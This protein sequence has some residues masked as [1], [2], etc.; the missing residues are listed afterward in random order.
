MKAKLV[1]YT[2]ERLNKSEKSKLSKKLFG[3]TDRSY[4][5]KYTYERKGLLE[6]TKHVKVYK[7]TF[8]IALED[9]PP[10]KEELGK[11]K[12]TLKVWN[13]TIEKF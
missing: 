1:T 9:W 5:S 2:T 11:R 6:G 7:N 12:A 4:H 10:I 13:I 3:Y 8:I